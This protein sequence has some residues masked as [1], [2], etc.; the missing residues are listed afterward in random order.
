M[1]RAE[2]L[3]VLLAGV[4]LALLWT[5]PLGGSLGDAVAFDP[6]RSSSLRAGHHAWVWQTWQASQALG[7]GGPYFQAGGLL[8]GGEDLLRSD[9]PLLPGVLAS[10]ITAVGGATLAGNLLFLGL[11]AGGFAAAYALLRGVGARPLAATGGALAWG[12]SPA[13]LGGGLLDPGALGG[14]VPPLFLLLLLRWM[15]L[16]SGAPGGRTAYAAGAGA[17]FA[18]QVLCAPRAALLLAFLGVATAVLAPPSRAGGIRTSRRGLGHAEAM[19]AFL[20][21]ALVGMLPFWIE[22]WSGWGAWGLFVGTERGI[23]GAGAVLRPAGMHPWLGSGT[24]AFELAPGF[25]LVGLAVLALVR[26][27]RSTRWLLLALALAPAPWWGLVAPEK[28][29]SFFLLPLA[30][31]AA[32]ALE[33]ILARGGK[34]LA[35][36][37]VVAVVFELQVAGIELADAGPPDPVARIAA[38]APVDEHAGAVCVVGHLGGAH[39]GLTWQT[40]HRRPVLFGP[41][42]VDPAAFQRWGQTAPD[43]RDFL[44]GTRLPQPDALALDLQLQEIDHVLLPGADRPGAAPLVELLDDM[45]GWERASTEDD[46]AWW[47]RSGLAGAV[48]QVSEG[49]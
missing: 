3:P 26:E 24:K 10:P 25:V 20:A 33:G 46:V 31:A 9:H 12:F 11:L 34:R 28:A 7:A 45:A 5:W 29:W 18:A 47:Y 39:A 35:L 8:V 16:G 37:L 41:Q 14:P 40:K 36:G 23:P 38:L 19:L 4:L 2:V 49:G 6:A 48:A 13:A 44:L 42:L 22:A 21:V 27:L 32:F 15:A 30:V 1:R 43:L 17:L